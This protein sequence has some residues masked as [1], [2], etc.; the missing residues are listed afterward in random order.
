MLGQQIE[1][2]RIDE[3][4]AEGGVGQVYRARDMVLGRDVAIK[5]LRPD[6]AKRSE[7]VERFRAEA[8][9]LG[10][11]NHPNISTLYSLVESPDGLLM[12]MEYVQGNTFS[13]LVRDVGRFPVERAIP[14]FVQVLE[15]VG[16]AH[17]LGFVHRDLK[18]SNIML[19]PRGV[20]KV[21]DFGIARAIG[22]KGVTQ[23]GQMVGTVHFMSP[24]QI[25]GQDT[26]A[27]SD[28]Y[29]LG[30]LLYHLLTG[31]LPFELDSDFDLMRAQIETPPPPPSRFAPDIPPALESVLLQALE[32][33]PIDRFAVADE[34]RRS[35]QAAVDDAPASSEGSTAQH[36]LTRAEMR[37]LMEN[38]PELDDEHPTVPRHGLRPR[39]A[40]A[41]IRWRWSQWVARGRETR[42][43]L[44]RWEDAL[45]EK[46]RQAW[47][48]PVLASARW[49]RRRAREQ[50]AHVALEALAIL[51]LVV[52]FNL[53]ILA[54][55]EP[56][57]PLAP[58]PP[59]APATVNPE[60]RIADEKGEPPADGPAHEPARPAKPRK[61]PAEGAG[62]EEGWDFRTP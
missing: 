4:I 8:Y 40:L 20:V 54:R 46:L 9:T 50:P 30:V 10:Q 31:R 1:N 18:G 37:A 60:P 3:L 61:K 62:K 39:G 58:E 28:I 23:T 52:G 51:L 24:E 55:S 6:L 19:T 15:G 45:Q 36:S 21:M 33:N 32:K 43:V 49:I 2:Y 13:A 26:D 5:L 7:L 35:L 22:S 17:E 42:A 44:R 34:F 14:L 38:P 53:L 48:D 16:Y 47:N 27:H 25:R 56:S 41:V 12:V 59:Q 57:P 11:L 29:S